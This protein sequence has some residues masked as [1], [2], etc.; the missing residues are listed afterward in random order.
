MD[1]PAKHELRT[2]CRWYVTLMV[3]SP[4]VIP[5]IFSFAVIAPCSASY[6]TK[7][8]PPRPGTVLTSRNPSKR[9]NTVD[10]A[11]TSYSSGTFCRKRILFGGRYSSGTTADVATLVDLSP[12]GLA[13]LLGLPSAGAPGPRLRCLSS[14]AASSAFLLS[15]SVRMR[16]A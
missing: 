16:Y 1:L 11:S 2:Y 3:L 9:P 10:R 7:A 14:S 12:D 5:A 4:K 15:A 6:S 8:I 13:A